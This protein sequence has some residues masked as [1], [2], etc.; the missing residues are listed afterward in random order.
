M[1]EALLKWASPRARLQWTG[2]FTKAPPKPITARESM[3]EAP[4]AVLQA[5]GATA[6]DP[7]RVSAASATSPTTRPVESRE[8]RALFS[9]QDPK[10]VST[11]KTWDERAAHRETQPGAEQ[12]GIPVLRE[13]LSTEVAAIRV[14]TEPPESA[15]DAASDAASDASLAGV[16]G[17][18]AS[19]RTAV[20]RRRR[21]PLLLSSA[22]AGAVAIGAA[23]YL[24]G[25]P[26][27]PPREPP[28]AAAATTAPPATPT[29]TTAI[30]PE[31]APPPA[32]PE[33]PAPQASLQK[34]EEPEKKLKPRRHRKPIVDENGIGI[35]SN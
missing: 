28:R 4:G 31:P 8:L 14:R 26:R 15:T 27:V 32:A 9:A 29:P 34:A 35:P 33:P 2:H 19:N 16:A 5:R 20:S 23:L 7:I 22:L 6:L 17:E 24:S 25:T 1:G 13:T 3:A 12:P 30:E 18:A 10:K 11:T 21:P